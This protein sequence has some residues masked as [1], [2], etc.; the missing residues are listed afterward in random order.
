[1]FDE[2]DA[3]LADTD[4]LLASIDDFFETSGDFSA[5]FCELPEIL[6]NF[7]KH[8]VLSALGL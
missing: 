2:A 8:F 3:L 7:G 5:D 1:L 6:L 4:D